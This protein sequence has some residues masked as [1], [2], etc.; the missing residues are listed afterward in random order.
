MHEVETELIAAQEAY[1]AARER[2]RRARAA[3]YLIAPGRNNRWAPIKAANQSRD[4]AIYDRYCAGEDIAT[5]AGEFGLAPQTVAA[6]IR[7]VGQALGEPVTL[8]GRLRP[9]KSR[10]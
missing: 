2:L 10:D 8:V 7:R 1:E 6:L 5:L 3:Y 4:R 9:R